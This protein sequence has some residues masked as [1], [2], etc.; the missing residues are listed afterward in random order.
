MGQRLLAACVLGFTLVILSGQLHSAVAAG[1]SIGWKYAWTAW[2]VAGILAALIAFGVAKTERVAWSWLC[3]VNAGICIGILVAVLAV[4]LTGSFATVG[5]PVPPAEPL[6]DAGL[7]TAGAF[8]FA[9]ASGLLGLVVTALAAGFLVAAYLL[10]R[11]GGPR[12]DRC[13]PPLISK[14]SAK[15]SRRSE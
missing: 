6:T 7:T 8:R 15:E 3:L 12:S 2:T 5:G 13:H 1:L 4:P 14:S 10:M 9:V 11:G